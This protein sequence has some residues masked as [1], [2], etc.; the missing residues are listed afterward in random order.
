[1]GLFGWVVLALKVAVL[2][3]FVRLMFAARRREWQR[4]AGDHFRVLMAIAFFLLV[5]QT[6]WEHYLTFLF[7]MLVYCLAMRPALGSGFNRLVVAIILLSIG[8]NLIVANVVRDLFAFDSLGALM[9]IGL[10][11]SGPLL[12]TAVLL[13]RY[14]SELLD[15]YAGAAWQAFPTTAPR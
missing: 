7:P 4:P 1:M 9:A 6:V 15:S 14:R 3:L 11:K 10:L 8:Q 2:A 12:C 5:S 13:T